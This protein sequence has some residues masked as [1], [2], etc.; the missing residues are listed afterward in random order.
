MIRIKQAVIVE[1]RY[2]KIKLSGVL[3][4]LILTT[5]GFGIFKDKEKLELIRSLAKTRGIVIMTDSDSAGFLIRNHLRGAVHEGEII[6][7]YIPE[8]RGREKR[9]THDSAEGLLGV[10]GIGDE[11]VLKALELAGVTAQKGDKRR[12]PVTKKDLYL[13]GFCGTADAAAKRESLSRRLG[14]PTRLSANMLPKVISDLFD[15]QEYER[16]VEQ[17]QGEF[18]VKS[19]N[20]T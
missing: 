17:V 18:V 7:V 8:I 16:A 20:Y 3:D 9:K 19:E 6:H 12:D 13:D 4:T 5:D 15:R 11:I 10:E 14:L 1:G 2:D